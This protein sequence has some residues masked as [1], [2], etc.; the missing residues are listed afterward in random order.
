MESAQCLLPD[1]QITQEFWGHAV[2]TAA[3]IHNRLPS[4]NHDN[5]SPI[6]FWTGKAPTIG[7]FRVF[8]ST[9][10][11][12]VPKERRRKLDAKSIKGILVG[13]EEE[14]GTK[15]YRVY[16]PEAKRVLVSR[17]VIIDESTELSPTRTTD[18]PVQQARIE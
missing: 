2:L 12:H 7:H 3:H 15:V 13:Y 16:D 10:W 11:V 9:A 17:D 18:I 6:E 4:R 5:T 1:L 14:A 8:G